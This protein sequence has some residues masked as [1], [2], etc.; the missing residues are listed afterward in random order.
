MKTRKILIVLSVLLLTACALAFAESATPPEPA[1]EELLYTPYDLQVR[2]GG[3]VYDFACT[4]DELAQQGVRIA[5]SELTAGRWHRANN[6]RASFGVLLQG[7]KGDES[8]LSV[9]GVQIEPDGNQIFELPGGIVIGRSTVDDCIAAWGEAETAS[10]YWQDFWHGKVQIKAY[11]DDS[12]LIRRFEMI[13]HGPVSWGF[14]FDGQAGKAQADLPDPMHMA[15]DEYILDGKLYA[16]QITIA[17][18]E[19]NGWVIDHS[20]NLDEKIKPQ[21]GAMFVLNPKLTCFNGASTLVVSPVNR[22]DEKECALGECA[23]QYISVSE[24]DGTSLTLADALTIGSRYS[25][26]EAL[27]G[28]AKSSYSQDE[29]MFYQHEVMGGVI[30]GFMVRSGVVTEIRIMP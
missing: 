21:G 17:D 19:E 28:T 16:G 29:G 13:S 8:E 20:M 4:L 5:Q 27:F 6:G 7:T 2:I 23:V 24:A 30:Y 11:Y 9:C 22:S 1:A 26:V 14:D 15:F 10:Q 3:K 25:E 12:G 18:L